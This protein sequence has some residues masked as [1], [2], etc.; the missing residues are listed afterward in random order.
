MKNGFNL[1]ITYTAVIIGILLAAVC[2]G[3]GEQTVKNVPAIA[4]GSVTFWEGHLEAKKFPLH[5]YLQIPADGTRPKMHV[6]SSRP[7]WAGPVDHL[8]LSGNHLSFRISTRNVSFSGTIASDTITGA[9]NEEPYTSWWLTMNSVAT[10]AFMFT[11]QHPCP[12][13]PYLIEEV[14]IPGTDSRPGLAGTITRPAGP[15][16]FPAILLLNG[17]HAQG[18]DSECYRHRPFLI[19]ADHLTRN[20][21]IVLRCDDRGV[22]GSEGIFNE[23]TTA[24]FAADAGAC[25]DFLKRYYQVGRVGILGHSEGGLVAAMTASEY[26]SADFLVLLAPPVFPI[27]R[28][29]EQQ[30]PLIN[31]RKG[32]S[33]RQA[34]LRQ[35]FLDEAWQKLVAISE[36]NADKAVFREFYKS[37]L[38]GLSEEDRVILGFSS[39]EKG[40]A[41]MENEL[42]EWLSP[43][44]LFMASFDPAASY[45][46]IACPVLGIFAGLDES[47][48]PEPNAAELEK[49]LRSG[50]CPSFKIHTFSDFD[51]QMR[52]PVEYA[53][54]AYPLAETVATETLNLVTGWIKLQL[55]STHSLQDF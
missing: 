9:W 8:Q 36:G 44:M 46:R 25:I 49:H 28:I 53:S 11:K 45:K 55:Q 33:E 52:R 21:L 4:P 1:D 37:F 3:C 22:G 10:P 29:W 17:Q 16:S 24:D 7:G 2:C 34:A 51:H 5:F 54:A 12:P 19:W 35:K 42:Q 39:A 20:G 48:L 30:A 40:R 18:R 38:A 50:Q 13:F 6:T 41:H 31:R 47:I 43:W 26:R 27:I 23:A 32:V 15:G 14:V